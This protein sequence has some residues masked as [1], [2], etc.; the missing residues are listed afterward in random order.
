MTKVIF[1]APLA[2]GSRSSTAKSSALIS[3]APLWERPPP[4]RKSATMMTRST[5]LR[6]SK[7]PR[8]RTKLWHRKRWN[9]R[10]NSNFKKEM[11]SGLFKTLWSLLI[12]GN[13]LRKNKISKIGPL[14]SS[15]ETSLTKNWP[16]SLD[17]PISRA[18]KCR[19]VFAWRSSFMT[20]KNWPA[21]RSQFAD[22]VSTY[23]GTEEAKKSQDYINSLD[24]QE[25]TDGSVIGAVLPADRQRRAGGLQSFAGNP[26]G[27]RP[28]WSRWRYAAE[29]GH[30]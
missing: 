4:K 16:T 23:P 25:R 27:R 10:Q 22:I 21:A 3:T 12:C 1:F 13:R 6:V 15:M 18:F 24:A 9:C 29:T 11:P 5:F 8:Q 14:K 7:S 26:N 28:F 30:H 20:Q 19:R 17:A 2:F